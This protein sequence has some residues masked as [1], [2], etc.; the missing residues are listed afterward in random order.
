VAGLTGARLLASVGGV[1]F[2]PWAP[3]TAGSLA[4]LA[5]G[6]VLMWVSPHALPIGVLLACVSGLWAIGR[7]S[8]GADAGWVVIDE[9]AGQWL[10]MVTLPRPTLIGLAA[11][12]ALFRLLDILKPGPIGWIDRKRGAVAVMA[13]DFIAGAIAAGALWLVQARFPGVLG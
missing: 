5:V 3:G 10:A 6:A 9:V 7:A 11:A 8:G 4:A 2:A 13:D 12:F 1:G